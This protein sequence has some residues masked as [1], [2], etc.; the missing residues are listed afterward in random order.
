MPFKTG[1]VDNTTA[2]GPNTLAHHNMLDLIRRF[3]AGDG[4]HLITAKPADITKGTLANFRVRANGKTETWTITCTAAAANAGTFSVTG[5]VSGAQAA[6]TVGVDYSNAFIAFTLMDGATDFI[7]GDSFTVTATANAETLPHLSAYSGGGNG[8]MT[9]FFAYDTGVGEFWTIKCK[10]VV[11]NG[12]VFS[13]VGSVSG[14]QAD[15]VVGTPYDNTRIKFTINDGTIDFGIGDQFVIAPQRWKVLRWLDGGLTPA[16]SNRELILQGGGYSG[17]EE[18]FVGFR[19]NHLESG[20]YYNMSSAIFTG[21][22]PS[23]T[24]DLQPGFAETGFCAHNIRLDYWL[25]ANGQRIMGAI[26]IATPIYENFYVGKFLPYANPGQYPYPM[27]CSGSLATGLNTTRFSNTTRAM[28]IKG[29][30]ALKMRFVDGSVKNPQTAP[31]IQFG[32][33]PTIRDTDSVWTLNPIILTD[34]AQGLY[35][36]LEGMCQ[37]TGFNNVVENTIT[38]GSQDWI[39]I[40]DTFRTGFNDYCA[41]ELK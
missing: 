27:V 10:T 9:G 26:K 34:A 2:T 33:A 13:V 37:V 23:A 19:A 3:C 25:C 32:T 20:D 40:Q 29:N 36:E 7:V 18:I 15:A 11:S 16:T 30:T 4:A 12:G 1:F 24:F 41:L 28:G 21:Y 14:A 8:T 22:V 6:A 31:W 38:V 35:G 39:V 5:S 17:D